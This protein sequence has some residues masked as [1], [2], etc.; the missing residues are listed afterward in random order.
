MRK[1]LLMTLL[2]TFTMTAAGQ[3]S[4]ELEDVKIGFQAKTCAFQ[5]YSITLNGVAATGFGNG[6]ISFAEFPNLTNNAWTRLK[7]NKT[8][9]VSAGQ[10]L[11]IT[12]I[13]FDVPEDYVMYI[14]GV[15]SKTIFKTNGGQIFSGD[16]SWSVVV[17]KKCACGKDEPGA[18]A[19]ELGSVAWST[20]LGKLRD[21][22]SAERIN[23]SE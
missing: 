20:S 15:E 9:T 13:N 3:E 7:L 17:R 8:Y 16:G 23:L 11:C 19:P 10:A 14:D 1:L 4:C 2:L 21:G 22:R 18:A 5:D 12:H 6:C